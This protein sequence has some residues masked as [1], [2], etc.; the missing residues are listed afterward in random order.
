VVCRAHAF[1]RNLRRHFY[2]FGD[3]TAT[4]TTLAGG[5]LLHAWDLLT[6]EPLAR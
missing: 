4:A 1:L 5:S 2:G 3:A 6:A